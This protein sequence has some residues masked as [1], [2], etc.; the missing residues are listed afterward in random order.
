MYQ[1]KVT[2]VD[3]DP[4]IWRR[5]RVPSTIPLCC[6][7]DALQAVMGWTNSHLHSFEKDGKSWG[8]SEYDELLNEKNVP[9]SSLLQ[10]KRDSL[11][12]VYDFGDDWRHEV[13][14]E[15]VI[16]VSEIERTPVCLGGERRCPPEDVGGP[17]AYQAF[18]EII[19]DPAHENYQ[20][21]VDWVGGHFLDEFDSKSANVVLGLMRWPIRHR[22]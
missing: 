22:S 15:Q 11:V 8:M 5:I 6:L 14:L 18:L 9:L 13:A 2:L 7:H 10:A 12:Y 21:L 19:L 1:L 20:Q 4:Q 16:P 17:L 3:T